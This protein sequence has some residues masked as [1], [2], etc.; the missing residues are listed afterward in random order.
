P[1]AVDKT[2]ERVLRWRVI[3]PEITVRSTFIVGFPG[4]TDAEFEQL[5]DFLD[6]AQL[7]RVGAFAYSPVEGATANELP[8]P[9]PEEVK[10]ERLARFME[11]QA[12]ISAAKLEAKIGSVQQCLVDGIEDG[13]A[14]ARSK[15]DA[16]E[17]D[18]LVH[19]QNAVEAK[20]RVGDFVNVEITDSDEHDLFGDA[21]IDTKAAAFDIKV[22]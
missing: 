22:L 3:A 20:L 9:V 5:L 11:K 21:L 15:A 4:E 17:I 19:I 1:G 2:L 12:A 6:T 7:D 10:Q 16:P 18:G 14:V 8:D 13:I